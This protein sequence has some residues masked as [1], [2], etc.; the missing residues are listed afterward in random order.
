MCNNFIPHST[1]VFVFFRKKRVFYPKNVLL[2]V[3]YLLYVSMF[4]FCHSGVK[5]FLQP[6]NNE[7][8][9]KW[10]FFD[11]FFCTNWC[12]FALCGLS[13]TRIEFFQ[14]NEMQLIM[15]DGRVSSFFRVVDLKFLLVK[16]WNSLINHHD[17]D[18]VLLRVEIT[19]FSLLK[20]RKF[21]Q[22]NAETAIFRPQSFKSQS[23]CTKQKKDQFHKEKLLLRK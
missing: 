21:S 15:M 11:G 2:S 16:G 3:F 22:L 10:L 4:F 9:A 19:L 12:V 1:A 5:C 7:L 20:I 8:Y 23:Y 18:V 13:I 14:G 6:L 17:S